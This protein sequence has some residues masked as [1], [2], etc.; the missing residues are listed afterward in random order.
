MHT[1]A[2]TLAVLTALVS[3]AAFAQP[4]TRQRHAEVERALKTYDASRALGNSVAGAG[5]VTLGVAAIALATGIAVEADN[6]A[7]AAAI[8]SVVPSAGTVSPQM[9]HTDSTAAFATAAVA[10]VVGTT[11]AIAGLVGR[12]ATAPAEQR[13]RLLL[14]K[15]RLENLER[16]EADRRLER[17]KA[18]LAAPSAELLPQAQPQAVSLTVAALQ[19][20]PLVP[21]DAPTAD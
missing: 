6:G 8:A 7:R 10:G 16:L 2:R 14:E 3:V 18:V 11:L 19:R 12:D 21:A 13:Q 4:S 20:K 17:V 5:A 15:D 1:S 9:N